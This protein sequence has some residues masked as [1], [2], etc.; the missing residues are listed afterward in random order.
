MEDYGFYVILDIE[1]NNEE[2]KEE[3]WLDIYNFTSELT[4]QLVD[5]T[6]RTV[7]VKML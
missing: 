4:K 5:S 3:N 1:E 7:H 6:E 2:N